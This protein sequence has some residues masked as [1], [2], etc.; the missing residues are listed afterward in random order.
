MTASLRASIDGT[1][2]HI[3][4]NGVDKV[5]V[6][7][8]GIAAGSYAPGSVKGTDLAV[9]NSPSMVRLNTA[10]GYGSTNN[11][12]RRFSTVVSNTGTDI[13]YAD[14]ASLGAS[15]TINTAGIYAISYSDIFNAGE[16]MGISI[17]T[18]APTTSVRNIPVAEILSIVTIAGPNSEGS[19][20][21]V[22]YFSAGAVLR[23]HTGFSSAAGAVNNTQF[24][25]TK[26][27]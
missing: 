4:V 2:T 17:N 15:F 23:A 24:T 14:S 18:S 26:V 13:T 22:G 16:I 1:K 25:I 9:N 8:Q 19:I 10:N 11:K 21:F 20:G 6:G 12:I 7:N 27:S 3:G 5:T